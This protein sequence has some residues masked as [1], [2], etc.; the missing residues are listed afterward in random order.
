MKK[1][2]DKV[3]IVGAPSLSSLE[4]EINKKLSDLPGKCNEIKYNFNNDEYI[5]VIQYKE[6]KN[7]SKK[8]ITQIKKLR[9]KARKVHLKERAKK[10]VSK[11][12]KNNGN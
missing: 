8:L 4:W 3:H 2:R 11:I 5:A 7:Y 10:L 9:D 6:S 1:S 12:R